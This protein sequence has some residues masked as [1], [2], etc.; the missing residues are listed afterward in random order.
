MASSVKVS[1]AERQKDYVES[2]AV[3]DDFSRGKPLLTQ[4]DKTFTA[5]TSV[6][7]SEQPSSVRVDSEGDLGALLRL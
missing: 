7:L 4:G 2:N 1:P 6:P 3:A 5:D